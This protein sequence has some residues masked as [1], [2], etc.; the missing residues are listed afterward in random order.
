MKKA[1]T[2]QMFPSS[3]KVKLSIFYITSRLTWFKND[4]GVFESS[5]VFGYSF[6]FVRSIPSEP[7]PSAPLISTGTG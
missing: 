5:E 1:K 4:E 3:N 2:E 7:K 6:F